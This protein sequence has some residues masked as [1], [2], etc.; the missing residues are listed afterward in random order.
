M[1][2]AVVA[3]CQQNPSEAAMAAAAA[4]MEAMKKRCMDNRYVLEIV[5]VQEGLKL[6]VLKGA[7][8]CVW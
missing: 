5:S 2:F 4:G 8:C 6:Y 3:V 7:L 1:I